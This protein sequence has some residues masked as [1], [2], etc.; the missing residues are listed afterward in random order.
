MARKN[1]GKT[2]TDDR[3]K[4]A[5]GNP[6]RPKG[7]RHKTTLA[8]EELLQGEAEGL[9]RKAVDLAMGGDTTALRLCLERIAPPR[10]D[11]PVEFELPPMETAQDAAQAAQAVL[12]AV[13]GGSMTPM[14]GASVMAL[15]EG[16][17][18]TLETSELELRISALEKAK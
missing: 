8:I 18:K 1:D 11:T 4:F 6:G 10:K 15:V 16:Y 14:E 3:G 2:Y 17:R 13:S 5:P 12:L 7:A 9:T